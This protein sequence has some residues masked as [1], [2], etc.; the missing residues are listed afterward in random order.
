M[1]PFTL[2]NSAA[3][4]HAVRPSREQRR[5]RGSVGG[6]CVRTR[7]E[8]R[9]SLASRSK[10]AD[11]TLPLGCPQAALQASLR[12]AVMMAEPIG[13]SAEAVRRNK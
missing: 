12:T 2:P 11:A 13:R 9:T 8:V 4:L 6:S 5:V 3:D 1:P 7:Q 10:W